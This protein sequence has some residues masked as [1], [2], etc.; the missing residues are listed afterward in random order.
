VDRLAYGQAAPLPRGELPGA[1]EPGRD[2]PALETPTQ[3]PFDFTIEAPTRSQIPRAVEELRFT[4]TNIQIEGAKTLPP[5]S[6]R[7]LYQNLLG[8]EVS[9]SNILDV[10]DAIEDAYRDQGYVLTHA[11]VPPQRVRNGV[12]TIDVVEGY[13][14]SV[15]VEG[16]DPRTQALVRSYVEPVINVRPLA[17]AAME[18]ALLLAN[19]I[20]GVTAA[21]VLRPAPNTP[22]A[23]DLVVTITETK[24][25]GGL[26]VD[27]RGSRFQDV[28]T[29]GGDVAVNGV[30]LA[31]DQLA[32]SY[33]TS[34]NV[35]EKTSG[36]VRYRAPVGT[37]G[38]TATMIV[39]VTHGEPGGSLKPFQLVTDSLAI[40]PRVSYPLIRT[41][42]E[43]LLLDGGITVQEAN[44]DT[45]GAQFSHDEWRVADLGV[46]YSRLALGGT[47]SASFDGAE[48]FG[49]FGASQDG[50]PNLSHP[51]ADPEFTKFTASFRHVRTLIGPLSLAISGQGQ[52]AFAPL[53]AGE[54]ITFGGSG[55]GRGYDPGAVTGDQG[56][57]GSAELRW[58]AHFPKVY[59]ETVEPYVYYDTGK[60]WNFKPNQGGGQSVASAGFGL[61]FYFPHAI[62]TDFEV[63]RTLRAVP[64]SDN[65]QKSTKLLM[66]ASI[67]F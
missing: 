18:R 9:V 61:R 21:G 48:G 1:V 31:G 27:N 30:A 5:E 42:A 38:T 16:G 12:F 2:R 63:S 28:W 57:G 43:S 24:V 41:R 52:Y 29:L 22:G 65:G 49:I 19:D 35:L 36:Q 6:F 37:N 47:W 13:V 56:V 66:D 55:I 20:P 3:P 23:S 46:T 59:L 10:A 7:P 17:L 32:A 40:G 15:T 34:P 8:Q 33:A 54:Q 53:V 11:Y 58:D 67:R 62:T 51:G 14:A 25:S 44:V 45:L 26:S 39:T 4:L 64:G 50:S 60:V